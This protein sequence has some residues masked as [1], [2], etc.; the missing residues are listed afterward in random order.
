MNTFRKVRL[1]T[2]RCRLFSGITQAA[3]IVQDTSSGSLQIFGPLAYGP[4]FYGPG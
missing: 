4:E 2:R 1:R 3:P